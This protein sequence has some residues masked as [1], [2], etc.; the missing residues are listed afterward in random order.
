[1]QLIIKDSKPEQNSTPEQRTEEPGKPAPVIVAPRYEIV[2]GLDVFI[3]V[4][5]VAWFVYT[6]IIYGFLF[7]K[8]E[9]FLY[10]YKKE[11][12]QLDIILAQIGVLANAH[13]VVLARFHNGDTDQTGYHLKKFSVCNK[14][15]APGA[16]DLKTPMINI[17]VERILQDIQEML[18]TH[19]Y[20]V[21]TIR[22]TNLPAGCFQHLENNSILTMHNKLIVVGNLPIGILS[23]QYTDYLKVEPT[24]DALLSSPLMKDLVD[25]VSM[26]LRQKV[27]NVS[28]LKKLAA[29]LKAV[30][31]NS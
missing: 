5:F 4:G 19:E 21:T 11:E 24:A 9:N 10:P 23:I 8:A 26:T 7:K 17:P 6:K 29:Q 30:S 31:P 25:T 20:W 12:A 1:M 14:Y 15:L 16:Q 2:L 28:V 18:V 27:T 22:N 3:I 13:R